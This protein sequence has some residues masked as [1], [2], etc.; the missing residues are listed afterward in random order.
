MFS[1]SGYHSGVVWSALM[2]IH[3]GPGVDDISILRRYGALTIS[4]RVTNIEHTSLV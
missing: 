1:E 3:I 2:S 4:G